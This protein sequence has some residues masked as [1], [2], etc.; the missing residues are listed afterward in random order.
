MKPLNLDNKP[1]SP[2]SSNCVVW[3][4]P[5]IECIEL[6]TG[7]T[8]SDVIAKLATEL[9]VILDQT[10]VSNY[11]LSCLNLADCG[12][13]DFKALI[14]LLIEKICELQNVTPVTPDSSSECPDCVVTVASCFQ[15][16]GA[17]TMQLIEY[18]QLI[19]EKVCALI[20]EIAELQ[21]QIAN[22][23]IRITILENIPEK[24]FTLPSIL[25]NC[26]LADGL[27]V[28]GSAYT[29]DVVLDALVNDDTYGY[30][31]LLGATGLPSDLLSAVATQ[32]IAGD[33]LTLDG[34]VTFSSLGGWINSPMTVADAI[35][36]IWL[37]I[38][39][40]YNYLNNFPTTIV[41]AGDGIDVTSTTVG[42]TTTYEVSA[43]VQDTGWVDLLGFDFFIPGQVKPQC[44]RMGNQIHFRG[45]VVV[46][47]DNLGAVVPFSGD[48]YVGTESSQVFTGIGGCTVISGGAIEFNNGTSIIPSSV[49]PAPITID[50]QIVANWIVTPRQIIGT[51]GVGGIATSL[52]LST[53]LRPIL[54]TDGVLR[55]QTIRDV[56][57]NTVAVTSG[58]GQSH[59]R[60]IVSDVRAGD[61]APHYTSLS[62]NIHNNAVSGVVG[63]NVDFTTDVYTFNCDAG[64]PDQIG[65]F[66]I[67]LE[68]FIAYL[69][70]CT[71]IE[72][73][74]CE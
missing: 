16:D 10:N 52:T 74:N 34:G 53:V 32:C 72:S 67:R 42:N 44:R 70:P 13:V 2:V 41:T 58:F 63:L 40:T 61:K 55:L 33:S 37:V 4:G 43:Q 45:R 51:A 22:L 17:T 68:G 25:V 23:D 31:A 47:I 30:C 26:T 71:T 50:D 19:A 12:P 38:C 14:Q 54:D 5:T 65:G 57:E 49:L 3:Q 29:I 7:D 59:L 11:D 62:T 48:D 39:D 6:C 27:V 9:C 1:C 64:E 73:F 35:T 36:N 15:E 60:Y 20:D 46:P 18:V 69:D 21:L 56:E 28:G 8:V 66:A 24:T